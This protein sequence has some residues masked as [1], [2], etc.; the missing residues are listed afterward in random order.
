MRLA[1]LDDMPH[2]LFL[3]RST[4]MKSQRLLISLLSVAAVSGWIWAL[5]LHNEKSSTEEE[6]TQVDPSTTR[7][8]SRT[9]IPK[10]STQSLAKLASS[11][12]SAQL[13]SDLARIAASAEPGSPNEALLRAC[14]QTMMDPDFVRRG[15][16]FGL[17]LEI[18][19]PEDAARIH[20][21]FIAMHQEGRGFGAEYGS[22]ATRW[23]EV[24]P[25]GA[26]T[27][28]LQGD[29]NTLSVRDMESIA[30]SWGTADPEAALR[31]MDENPD[32]AT[33]KE[34]WASVLK[35]WFRNDP[36]AATT[37]LFSKNLPP[38][39]I[40]ETTRYGFVE[41]LFSTG[42]DDAA[43][44]LSGLDQNQLGPV[45]ARHAWVNSLSHLS[46]LTPERAASAWGKLGSEPW[47]DF[48]NF[49]SFDRMVSKNGSNPEATAGFFRELQKTWPTDQ[50]AAQ[51]KRW[52]QMDQ[53]AVSDWLSSAPDTEFTNAMRHALATP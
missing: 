29:P 35:G 50:A 10:T 39:Q 1:S 23:G 16:D 18:M 47:M 32:V 42:L 6:R 20:E 33:A 40:I 38:Q 24:D 37:Y 2:G 19:R 45:A 15:R 30:R 5:K 44:W 11:T 8:S 21:Q 17:L 51:F 9:E 4:N 28:L 43:Q 7:K 41:K 12:R 25:R 31:W 14:E 53:Q 46:E 22:F 48:N 36:D 3:T 26:L 52:Q 34:G 13:Y 27:Y 49:V